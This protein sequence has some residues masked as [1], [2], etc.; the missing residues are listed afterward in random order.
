M[1]HQTTFC[2]YEEVDET[3]VQDPGNDIQSPRSQSPINGGVA[4]LS[5]AAGFLGFVIA[6]GPTTAFGIFQDYYQRTILA[7]ST[8]SDIAWIGTVN[9]FLL[10]ATG[11]C[12]GPLFDRGYGKVL[13]CTG[14]L[15]VVFGMMMLSISQKYYQIMLAQGVCSG[16][17]AGI[18][19]VPI[20]ALVN[21]TFVS[22]KRA[23]ANGF[24]TLG[25][26]VGM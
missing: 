13:I 25:A 21:S 17:G 5:V 3:K 7:N 19:Y 6:W 4:W 20:L 18:I 10:V 14:C 2:P 12:S 9:A 8:A 23:V 26:S 16:I 22:V 1:S 15:T 24:V 11:V